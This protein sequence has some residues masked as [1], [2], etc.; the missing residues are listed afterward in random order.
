MGINYKR[1]NPKDVAQKLEE[2]RL[3]L[4]FMASIYREQLKRG[5]HLIHEHPASA[6]SWREDEIVKLKSD[7]RVHEV[8]C[9]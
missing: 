2:G 4:S 5:R 7:P 3:H 6:F 8:V 9:D 1:M